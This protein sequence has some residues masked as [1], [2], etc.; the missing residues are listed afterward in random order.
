MERE[1][2]PSDVSDKERAFVASYLTL[3]TEEAPQRVY[4]LREAFN[5]LRW[6]VRAGAP[7]R[8]MPNDLPL[9]QVVCQQM[10]RWLKAGVFEA[11]IHRPARFRRLARDHERPPKTLAGFRFHRF[12]VVLLSRSVRLITQ[13][14]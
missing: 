14:A 10:Q 4:P 3:M 2:Y 13:S 6:I 7:C 5:A 9:G 8:M 1:A 11:I 12:A